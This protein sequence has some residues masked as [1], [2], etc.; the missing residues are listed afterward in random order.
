MSKVLTLGYEYE[1]DYHLMAINSTLDDYRLAYYLNKKLAIYLERQPNNIDFTDKNCSFTWY[2][3]DCNQTFTTWA[4]VANKHVFTTKNTERPTL[5]AEESKI[6]YLISEKKKV[7]YFLKIFG[8]FTA[9]R[10]IVILEKIKSIK[11]VVTSYTLNPQTL[12]SKDFLI[13]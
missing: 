10:L 13:F 4:L 8:D 12:K 1:H 2:N 11:G 9:E 7:D 6:S 3:Y 5:F